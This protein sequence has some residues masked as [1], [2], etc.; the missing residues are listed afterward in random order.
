MTFRPPPAPPSIMLRSAGLIGDASQ[1]T[2]TS[3]GPIAG[4]GR[5]RRVRTR[6]G[7]PCSSYTSA[8]VVLDVLVGEEED[9]AAA[10]EE[11]ELRTR[12]A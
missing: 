2:S 12:R 4:S 1:R 5:S 10:A 9:A 6:P 11:E 7:V 3:C 8:R